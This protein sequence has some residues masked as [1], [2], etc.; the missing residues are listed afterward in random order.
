MSKR[1]MYRHF[2]FVI[3]PK[4]RYA[5]FHDTSL[6]YMTYEPS[7]ISYPIFQ[8]GDKVDPLILHLLFIN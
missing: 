6:S 4:P 5:L 3:L 8:R 7:Y 1:N 2:R